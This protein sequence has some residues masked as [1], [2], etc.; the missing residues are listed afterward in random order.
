M[1]VDDPPLET[2]CDVWGWWVVIL[3]VSLPCSDIFP[4]YRAMAALEVS[5]ILL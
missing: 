3:L 1:F 2:P 5:N 4:F